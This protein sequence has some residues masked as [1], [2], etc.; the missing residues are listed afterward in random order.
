MTPA[1]IIDVQPLHGHWLRLWFADDAI[2]DVDAGP[3]IGDGEVFA[4]IRASRAVFEQVHA[5]GW[6]IVWPGEIDLCPD[7]LY[8]HGEPADGTRF[9][10]RVIRAGSGS[11][12]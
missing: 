7:V 9:E 5:D 3:L 10:R 12:A 1:R 8:G 11:A 2:I 4:H 6:T